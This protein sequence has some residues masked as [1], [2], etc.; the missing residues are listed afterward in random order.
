MTKLEIMKRIA[1]NHNRISK[2]LV[3]SDN[4]ILV[5]DTIRD[6]R[7]LTVELQ[8]DVEAEQKLVEGVKVVEETK[9]N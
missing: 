8:A 4:A 2:V 1:E 5:G 6:L 7:Q 3:S 9:E